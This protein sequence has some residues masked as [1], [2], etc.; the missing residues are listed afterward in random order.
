MW[1]KDERR[2]DYQDCCT[3]SYREPGEEGS[4]SGGEEAGKWR[5][6]CVWRLLPV[7]LSANVGTTLCHSAT[8]RSDFA[9]L[10]FSY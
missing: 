7:F 1:A 8:A 5:E 2:H 9:V 10:S 4:D 3:A 6:K